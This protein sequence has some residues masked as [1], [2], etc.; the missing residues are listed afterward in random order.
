M[1]GKKILYEECHKEVD[2]VIYKLC[3]I[4]EEWFSA[5]LENFYSKNTKEGLSPYCKKCENR[6]NDQWQKNN[7]DRIKVHNKKEYKKPHVKKYHLDLSKRRQ[8]NGEQLKWQRNNKD[9]LKEYHKYRE[10]HKSHKITKEEW[11][12]C[13]EYFN[14]QCA[15]CGLLLDKHY[16]K[17]KG[18]MR[19]TDFHKE[20]VDH[21]GANDLSNCI[22]SCKTCNS[23]KHTDRLEDWYTEDKEFFSQER[24]DK[25]HKWLNEDY[26]QYIKEPKPKRK[27]NK[28][29]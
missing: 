15:Y 7:P 17:Y 8:E 9:K 21:N 10:L 23:S 14:N 25:I 13:K 28:K 18:E 19:L 24:L 22:P 16:N 26:K 27:Y 3:K 5:N 20:H 1:R 11:E 4:C 2:G 6:K 12:S 29:K